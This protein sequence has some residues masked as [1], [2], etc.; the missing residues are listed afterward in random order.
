MGIS[1]SCISLLLETRKLT[2]FKGNIL[3]LGRQWI[4]FSYDHLVEKAKKHNAILTDPKKLSFSHDPTYAKAKFID[5]ITF[6][7]SLGFS[8]VESLDV[9]D[10]ESPTY[11]WDLNKPIPA[12]FHNQYDVILDG[13]TSE[14]IC[15]IPQ[16]LKNIHLMLKDDGIVIHAA[17]PIHNH[18]DHGY[19]SF[20]PSLFYDYYFVNS[21][22]ILQSYILRLNKNVNKK[23]TLYD[24]YPGKFERFSYGGFDTDL[25]GVY[26]VC[27]KTKKSTCDK[28]PNQGCS[29]KHIQE[30]IGIEKRSFIQKVVE[31]V[32]KRPLFPKKLIKY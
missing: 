26:F 25:W 1:K 15:N 6:F 14:H 23:W 10:A 13:G 24:Y 28:I 31:K 2:P 17:N 32:M 9:T 5:D 21:Y 20:S 12:K 29:Q 3:Q 7:E 8:K 22:D 16:V 30:T 27:K 4:F 11:T 19:Y 18:V